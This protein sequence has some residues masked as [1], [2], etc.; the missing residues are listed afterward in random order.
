MNKQMQQHK[1][2]GMK[3]LEETFGKLSSYEEV[4]KIL[5]D[6]NLQLEQIMQ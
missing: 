4:M 2:E 3:A 5:K 6:K 1:A